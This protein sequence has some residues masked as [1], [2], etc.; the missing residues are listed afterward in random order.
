MTEYI[1]YKICL[2]DSI[3]VG[4]TK[5]GLRARKA[6]HRCDS[7]RYNSKVN[8]KLRSIDFDQVELI[9]LER[10]VGTKK[11]A[12]TCEQK[13]MDALEADLNTY[14]ATSGMTRKEYCAKWQ[15]DNLPR[16][17][18]LQRQWYGRNR[19]ESKKK[20]TKYRA[21]HPELREKHRCVCGGKYTTQNKKMHETT[22]RHQRLEKNNVETPKV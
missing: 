18:E 4:S 3:Y 1:V 5:C 7:Q 15:S 12:V 8:R 14:T 21:E 10:V 11:D 19:E 9:E 16:V 17:R 22:K 20:C 6:C 13:W 2:P